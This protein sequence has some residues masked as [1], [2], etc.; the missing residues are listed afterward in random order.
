MI[1]LTEEHGQGRATG[2]L[3]ASDTGRGMTHV[4]AL[5]FPRGRPPPASQTLTAA[6][7]PPIA[8]PPVPD[9]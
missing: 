2:R 6:P 9:R 7:P 8:C 5:Y 4:L 1:G 3:P